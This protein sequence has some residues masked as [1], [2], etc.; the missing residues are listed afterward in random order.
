M[1]VQPFKASVSF[2]YLHC[3][4]LFNINLE[5]DESFYQSLQIITTIH[6]SVCTTGKKIS[7]FRKTL[8]SF[9]C[10]KKT[11]NKYCNLTSLF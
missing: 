2:F 5:S 6:T 9:L 10:A 3:T 1:K 8:K 4:M 11:V 7:I